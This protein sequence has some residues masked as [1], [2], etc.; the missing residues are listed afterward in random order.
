MDK[1]RNIKVVSQGVLN[2]KITKCKGSFDCFKRLVDHL[3]RELQVRGYRHFMMKD[4]LKK[5]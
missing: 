3:P 1:R 5:R 4:N 2:G